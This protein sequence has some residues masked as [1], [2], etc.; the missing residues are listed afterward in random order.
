ETL[1]S[2]AKFVDG[3]IAQNGLFTVWRKQSRVYLEVSPDQL[4]RSY[5]LVPILASGL[6]RGLFAG[7]HF[8]T[9][10]WT[11]T[12]VGNQ[13]MTVEQNP[14]GKAQPGTPIALAVATS[15]PQSVISADAIVAIDSATGRIVFGADAL[16]T[17]IVDLT[18][19]LNGPP[20]ETRSQVRYG[21]N[22][23]L[24]YFGPSKAFPTNVDIEADLT[25][26]SSTAGAIDTVPD[27]R[28]LFIRMHYSIVDMPQHGYR[29]RLADD[30]LGYFITARRQY[31]DEQT[32]TSFVRYINRW[33]IEKTDPGARLSKARN[34]I[35]FYLSKDIPVR[36]R[37][38]I[39]R[40]LLTWNSAFEKIG[41]RGAIAVRQQPDDPTWDPDDARYSV[42]RWVVSPDAA[43]AYG[44]SYANPLTGEI[45]RGDIVIDGNLVRFGRAQLERVVEPT[46]TLTPKQRLEC[47]LND[48]DYGYEAR[49]QAQW[50]ALVLQSEG[51][52]KANA[53][54]PEWFVDSYLESI[55]LHES[56]HTLGLRHNF[57]SSTIFSLNQLRDQR[58]THSH[59]LV[60]SV[61]E[62]TPVNLSPHGQPQGAY[63]QTQLGP[64]DYFSI[65]YGYEPIAA[66]SPDGELPELRRVASQ[67]TRPELR[68][69][70][71]EDNSWVDGFATDPRVNT[72]DLSNDPL[73]YTSA[74]LTIDQRLFNTMQTRLPKRGASYAETRQAFASTLRSWWAAS[75]YATH[76]MGGEYFTR[77]HR[78]DPN[79]RLPF[80]PVSR[81][82]ERRAFALLDRYVFSDDAFRFSPSLLNSLGD[83][84]FYHW[85][86]DPN[87]FDRLDFP[88]DEFVEAYQLQLLAQMWQPTVLA[89]LAELESRVGR[90][91]DTMSLADL[92][93]WTDASMWSDLGNNRLSSV[94]RQHRAIQHAYAE[95]LIHI[96]LTPDPGTPSDARTLA[97]HHLVWLDAQ[98]KSALRRS[99]LD[100]ATTANLEDIQTLVD[101][102]LQANAILPLL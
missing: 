72:F 100:E 75:R 27:P 79:A 62:Y 60:G 19:A 32:P 101:R 26:S 80:T 69:A 91:G 41:I 71:D 36:Y 66:R 4:D 13:I 21:L 38:P 9:Q 65:K 11:F 68:Y 20:G 24:S 53:P 86:N 85:Q 73:A 8:K 93:D 22:S 96:M 34:P 10:L 12:R 1:M 59:G 49:D 94:P 43:F 89:R 51:I 57:E 61:M 44:P 31:D 17:D 92:F 64:W 25:M 3:A 70:T 58:F 50:A 52:F 82:D 95:M 40:A 102:A 46:R 33:N 29:P 88:L 7:L 35:V 23:R 45:F 5:L 30:R 42:V 67:T 47:S 15:Y 99:G 55:V 76:Y 87:V 48:C 77:N 2:Y 97:R 28:S 83:D 6:G 16:L 54:P 74:I 39:T 14:Y 81:A 18:S 98:L 78:G 37:A 63:F 84:R 90:P 56:G